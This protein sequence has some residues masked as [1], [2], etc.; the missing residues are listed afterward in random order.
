VK[1]LW[2]VTE[3]TFFIETNESCGMHVHLSP[4]DNRIWPLESLQRLCRSALWFEKALEAVYP[5]SR[6][7]NLWCKS[8]H[9][10]NPRLKAKTELECF[11]LI[12]QCKN[13]ID[14]MEL[15]NNG[16]DRTFGW[17]F[18][19][20]QYSHKGTIEWRK[21]PGVT[22]P[23]TCL[24]WVELVVAF[25]GSAMRFGLINELSHYN[26]DVDGLKRF[27]EDGIIEELNEPRRLKRIFEEISGKVDPIPVGNPS[28]RE[29]EQVEN[30]AK[31]EHEKEEK[32]KEK[33]LNKMEVK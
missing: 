5:D 10:D 12:S 25:V 14:V 6:R 26:Q 17:N 15:M 28:P 18:T 2:E 21:G 31:K 3:E 23:E 11:D 32:K 1:F 8:N 22:D 16:S 27:I 33:I 29:R 13:N 24:E 19:N 9:L 30:K 7:G 4:I 20:L